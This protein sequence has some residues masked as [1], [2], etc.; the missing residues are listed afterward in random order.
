MPRIKCNKP[1]CGKVWDD[2]GSYRADSTCSSEDCRQKAM[3]KNQKPPALLQPYKHHKDC[4]CQRCKNAKEEEHVAVQDELRAIMSRAA[5]DSKPKHF[6]QGN[7]DIV[8]DKPPVRVYPS[9]V[10]TAETQ[11]I[12]DENEECLYVDI[13]DIIVGTIYNRLGKI[14]EAS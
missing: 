9:L 10:R 8:F 13:P 6:Q 1:G 11:S 7:P 12:Y 2:I 5:A 3:G 14:K 4:L